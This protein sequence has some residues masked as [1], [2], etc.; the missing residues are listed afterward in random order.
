[1]HL[2]LAQTK[3]RWETAMTAMLMALG[4]TGLGVIACWAARGTGFGP[5]EALFAGLA[6]A[7]ALN[8]HALASLN[9]DILLPTSETVVGER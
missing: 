7:G 9:P 3:W 8:I 1:V 6:V 2:T 4:R 5:D